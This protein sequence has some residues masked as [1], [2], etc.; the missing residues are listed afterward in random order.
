MGACAVR[1]P[2]VFA[3]IDL[4]FARVV[5]WEPLS[6]G[7]RC[8]A[9]GVRTARLPDGSDLDGVSDLDWVGPAL[10][11]KSKRGRWGLCARC[12]VLHDRLPR[13]F[14][15]PGARGFEVGLAAAPPAWRRCW[16]ATA[17]LPMAVIDRHRDELR[18]P[19]G[20]APRAVAVANRRQ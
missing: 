19:R 8:W 2:R 14:V 10:L 11:W 13:L 16:G 18:S 7:N 17:V 5:Q 15:R 4:S 6:S 3:A 9:A 12:E 1:S 20:W